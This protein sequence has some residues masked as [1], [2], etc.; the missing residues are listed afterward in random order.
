MTQPP[1][2][3]YLLHFDRPYKGCQHYLG[4]TTLPLETRLAALRSPDRFAEVYPRA[5]VPGLV[6]A[7]VQAGC[8]WVLADVWELPTQAEAFTL[9]RRLRRHGSRGR[10]CSVCAPGNMKGSRM[11]RRP[12]ESKEGGV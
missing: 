6:R 1:G 3:V 10:L 11:A 5:H 12:K 7:A 4:T 2:I 9:L 8:T